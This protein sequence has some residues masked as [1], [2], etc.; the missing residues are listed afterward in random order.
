MPTKPG[1]PVPT[2]DDE[3]EVTARSAKTQLEPEESSPG[4]VQHVDGP[5][6][7][8]L[9]HRTGRYELHRMLG[10]GGMGEIRLCEDKRIG[11]E[12]AVKSMRA[13]TAARRDALP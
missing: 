12:V 3:V 11:R 7:T 10:E 9:E 8:D 4:T 6:T 1:P 5:L 2:D 13:D